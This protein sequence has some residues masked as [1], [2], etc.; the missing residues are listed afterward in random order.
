MPD[1]SSNRRTFLKVTAVTG[2][3]GVAGCIGD[4]DVDP[5]EEDPLDEDGDEAD[6]NGEPDEDRE[7]HIDVGTSAGGTMDVGLAVEQGVAE[8][9]D[10][11]SYSTVESPGYVGSTYR[12]NEDAFDA[13][14]IDTNTMNKAQEG[15]DMFEEDPVDQLPWQGML[16]FPYS[17]YM[18]ARDGTGIETFD[19]LA[20]ASVYPAEPGYSTRATTLD[21]FEQDP[22]ADVYD[23]MDIVDMDVA[24]A[25]GAM[26]EE[27]IDAAIAYGT[28]GIGNTGWV[29]EYD[30]RV[31][32]HY[33][34]H[35]D[36]LIEAIEQ[37]PGAGLSIYDDNPGEEFAWDQDID[38]DEI[39][40]WDLNVT[41]ATHP[42]TPDE[43]IYELCRVGAEHG[44]TIRNAEE[45]FTP[46]NA[47]D[48]LQGALD[49]YPFH[50]GAAEF[51]QDEG[52]WDDD[53]VVGDRD[54]VGEY[55]D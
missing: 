20:G 52:V 5:D 11:L 27:R 6:A 10:T 44:D 26:E 43:A 46:E 14:F 51:Y 37:F 2:T 54:E 40:A 41:V 24:D 8:E 42:E 39:A 53:W 16:A 23:E 1:R 34:E 7:H 21:V 18:M 13:A 30:A 15:L 33:V 36:A 35:T 22:I 3:V 9:S 45:R 50:P 49:D 29:V 25:P 48:L 28:P 55:F 12:M 19:D 31:D 47:E 32:V 17:I 4:E 38:T